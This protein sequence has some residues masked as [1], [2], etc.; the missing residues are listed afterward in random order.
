MAHDH[1]YDGRPPVGQA[2][3]K[4]ADPRDLETIV[5]LMEMAAIGLTTMTST[6]FTRDE[7]LREAQAYG[8]AEVQLREV[9]FDIV[10]RHASFIRRVRGRRLRLR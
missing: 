4:P 10:L 6:T 5:S 3:I 2:P 7:L 8:G 1:V 9:D